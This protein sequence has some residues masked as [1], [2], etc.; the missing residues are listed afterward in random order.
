MVRR[1]GTYKVAKGGAVE[2]VYWCPRRVPCE[3][4]IN[5]YLW[6]PHE[7][8]VYGRGM[9]RLAHHHA[10]I[11][12]VP[13]SIPRNRKGRGGEADEHGVSSNSGSTGNTRATRTV[14]PGR[15]DP[16]L[17]ESDPETDETQVQ[18]DQQGEI[19][20]ETETE[21]GG[22]EG[23]DIDDSEGD[24]EE[25]TGDIFRRHYKRASKRVCRMPVE[26]P[27]W[28]PKRSVIVEVNAI[29]EGYL[30]NLEQTARTRRGFVLNSVAYA[31][32]A[33]ISEISNRAANERNRARAEY[34]EALKFRA[35]EIERN[36]HR[37]TE[38]LKRKI[39]YGKQ[40]KVLK[41]V[42]ESLSYKY[43]SLEQASLDLKNKQACVM[44]ELETAKQEN[45]RLAERQKGAKLALRP[46]KPD[47]VP[48][49]EVRRYWEEIVGTEK[50]FVVSREFEEWATE[51]Q[52]AGNPNAETLSTKEWD[53]IFR[54]L[55]PW[56]AA[57]PDGLH[58]YWWKA[59]PILRSKAIW[60]FEKCLQDPKRHIR[61]WMC[62]GMTS[63]LKKD[64]NGGDD[65][66]N[67][68][69]IAGLNT[70]YKLLTAAISKIVLREVGDKIP[71]EQMA[72]AKGKWGCTHAHVLDQATVQNACRYKKPLCMLWVDMC[73]AYDSL[74]RGAIK[75]TLM[76]WG[77]PRNV[78]WMTSV[79]MDL[80]AV[81]FV[82]SL[83]GKRILSDKLEIKRGVMQGDTLSP[84][85]Y[86]LAISPIS[87]WIRNNI[88]RYML[89]NSGESIRMSHLFYMD[90][91]KV[92]TNSMSE[93]RKCADGLCKIAGQMG[94]EMNPQ[95]SAIKVLN[96]NR[97]TGDLGKIR[98]IGD[99]SY[100]YL[101][102][103]QSDLAET[104]ETWEDAETAALERV[105]NI[106]NTKLTL[107]QK[108]SAINSQCTP[109][110]AYI[111]GNSIFGKGRYN[112]ISSR[113]EKL[114]IKIREILRQRK[115]EGSDNKLRDANTCSG[116]LYVN[117]NRGGIGLAS[118]LLAVEKAIV[119]TASYITMHPE[120]KHIREYMRKQLASGRRTVFMDFRRV[121][122]RHDLTADLE[123]D[124][125]KS[126]FQGRDY[127][128]HTRLAAAISKQMRKNLEGKALE[129][130][131]SKPV[132]GRIANFQEICQT[133]SYLWLKKGH[134]S[135]DVA[136]TVLGAQEGSLMTNS[137]A[138]K[139]GISV[140][141][142]CRRCKTDRETPEHVISCCPYQRHTGY[143]QR[144]DAV[145]KV[146]YGAVAK[147]YGLDVNTRNPER[148]VSNSEIDLLWDQP[149]HVKT[150]IRYT[151][152]DIVIIDK[153]SREAHLIE[154][155]V[156][157]YT[158]LPSQW[159]RKKYKYERNGTIP[160][161]TTPDQWGAG[162]NLVAAMKSDLKIDAKVYPIIIGACGEV[163]PECRETLA[164]LLP[165]PGHNQL[166]ERL[167]R[168]AIL[169]THMIVK[170]HLARTDH[171]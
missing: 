51:M 33:T 18:E 92:Y 43:E 55:K 80:N 122:E 73:K 150:S 52:T 147:H 72:M 143:M 16:N 128:H 48:V 22:L 58:A 114:D 76:K 17:D 61:P 157:W 91:L 29:A 105:R 69:P 64:A 129:E 165:K 15:G 3:K 90:D 107:R 21:A 170:R 36:I 31:A 71:E 110:M 35:K 94:L 123:L 116:R 79:L 106:V 89:Q 88:G 50:P 2:S 136:R 59:L 132:A 7:S 158:R 82:G 115:S 127:T 102:I 23:R 67:F 78:R 125:K 141:A 97:S 85:L 8:C 41:S 24:L 159:L 98:E 137:T 4:V 126:R 120:L 84:L 20:T 62:E 154:I 12:R 10:L 109:R 121:I 87:H 38:A 171:G 118:M 151:K 40:R 6:Q 45:T 169:G 112:C 164:E 28:N 155:G 34:L 56:K 9:R 131:Q 135:F 161:D 145:A 167:E 168:A 1:S 140:N 142:M 66:S 75:W 99:K 65:P 19:R 134:V 93:L 37:I 81:R 46:K 44:Q 30:E 101:G 42:Q 100:K 68:R 54:K 148:V 152:P 108:V 13:R 138:A 86:I 103:L 104:T 124:E 60:F 96:S 162:P 70:F 111:A 26:K 146:I 117:P 119:Y 5:D 77:I 14:I 27:N 32:A 130:W 95:K 25:S 39:G 83:N 144:H 139:M 149:I 133:D 74:S 153:R 160:E 53:E 49:V 113:A 156:S 57:G 166:I 63:L 47:T 163:A 11:I